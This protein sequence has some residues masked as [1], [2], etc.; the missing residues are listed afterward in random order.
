MGV[1]LG[2]RVHKPMP[3]TLEFNN[4]HLAIF[5]IQLSG[6][7][8]CCLIR[9]IFNFIAKAYVDNSFALYFMGLHLI[10]LRKAVEKYSQFNISQ[11]LH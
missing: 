10:E 9:Q 8:Y 2:R 7:F 3:S 11:V 6:F 5:S 1:V 4:L